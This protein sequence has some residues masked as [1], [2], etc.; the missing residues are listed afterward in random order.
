MQTNAKTN[1]SGRRRRRPNQQQQ[2]QQQLDQ[3]IQ[4]KSSIVLSLQANKGKVT[5]LERHKFVFL[6]SDWERKL[7]FMLSVAAE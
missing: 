6:L 7:N 4:V 5:T 3:M 1:E 2:Q